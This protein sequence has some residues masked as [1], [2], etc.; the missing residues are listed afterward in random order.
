MLS[1][2]PKNTIFGQVTDGLDAVDRIA[3]APTH[4]G[5]EGSQPVNPARIES[6]TIDETGP[7][8]A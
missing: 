1:S 3:T 4:P 6:I 2:G 5:G 8:A 7:D